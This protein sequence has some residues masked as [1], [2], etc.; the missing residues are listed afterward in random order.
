MSWSRARWAAILGSALH[1]FATVILLS[2]HLPSPDLEGIQSIGLHHLLPGGSL[3]LNLDGAG[4]TIAIFDDGRV[5]ETHQ[6]LVGRVIHFNNLQSTTIA[7]HATG[8]A[9]LIGSAGVQSG[10]IGYAPA[11]IL[12]VYKWNQFSP[13]NIPDLYTCAQNG[14]EISNHSYATKPGWNYLSGAW[15]WYGSDSISLI[16]DWRFGYYDHQRSRA[17]D[18]VLWQNPYHLAVFAAG[19][20]RGNGPSP[21]DTQYYYDNQAQQWVDIT[22]HPTIHP[23]PDGGL[24]GFDCLGPEAVAKNVL[25][26][27]AVSKNTSGYQTPQ[28]IILDSNSAF[29]PTDDGRIKPEVVAPSDA[30]YTPSSS[31]DN[32]Y[33]TISRTSAATAVASGTALL[34]KTYFNR[35]YGRNPL[36]STLRALI[37][38]SA[39]RFGQAP[40][41][42]TGFG[43]LNAYKAA[44]II[45][46][47][48]LL[49]NGGYYIREY[50]LY[51]GQRILVP[52][53]SKLND[54]IRIT[55]AWTD[56]HISALPIN[57]QVLN[58]RTSRLV[59]DLDI[60]LYS[61]DQSNVFH[62]YKGDPNQPHL[63]A[64]TGDNVV[65]N[66]EM[67]ELPLNQQGNF[68]LQ[69]THKG[70][71]SQGLQKF[72][73]VI[74]GVEEPKVFKATQNTLWFNSQNWTSNNLPDSNALVFLPASIN[75]LF[76]DSNAKVW[77]I[78]RADS[79]HI[80][81]ADPATLQ[82]Q[83]VGGKGY[84]T[85]KASAQN[86]AGISYS[87]LSN[88]KFIR[89]LYIQAKAGPYSGRWVYMGL[90]PGV[91]LQKL[92]PQQ[93]TLVNLNFPG[94]SL[95]HW[96]ASIGQYQGFNSLNHIP[97]QGTGILAFFGSNSLGTF[98]MALPDTLLIE[99]E[100]D[101]LYSLQIPIDYTSSPLNQNINQV[102][103]GWNLIANPYPAWYDWYQQPVPGN[104]TA[105]YH[106]N[107]LTGQWLSYNNGPDSLRY[108]AP[109]QAFWVRNASGSATHLSFDTSR[110]EKTTAKHFFKPQS[111]LIEFYLRVSHQSMPQ[112]SDFVIIGNRPEATPYFDGQW[113]ALKFSNRS[114]NPSISV[115]TDTLY[116]IYRTHNAILNVPLTLHIH[117]EGVYCFETSAEEPL[118]LFDL[119]ENKSFTLTKNTK[120]CMP[121]SQGVHTQRFVLE[122][123]PI[124]NLAES[125]CTTPTVAKFSEFFIVTNPSSHPLTATLYSLQGQVVDKLY[126]APSS[127][128]KRI[129]ARRGVFVL[130]LKSIEFDK[131]FKLLF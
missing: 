120:Q 67:I 61:E 105:I 19:N 117:Q 121:V 4:D 80:A 33:T 82:A 83:A 32:S 6:E 48:S 39:D 21:G 91:S 24:L 15:Y 11:V 54:S 72:S 90:P 118:Q 52:I 9:G 14:V 88:T 42:K 92:V 113:D 86:L 5:R 99:Y 69:I 84:I 29:G 30:L 100:A 56:P 97:S 111:T 18:S 123:I 3:G 36:S 89:Q 108:I 28:D 79:N 12:H 50:T 112:L 102:S 96:N 45:R 119:L 16:E 63:P 31:A 57:A 66:V 59:N 58:N 106:F 87:K 25:T 55:I 49:C 94:G 73:L 129:I 26:V 17:L 34:L 37:V 23:Q 130:H 35:V 124:V 98:H 76:I 8:I 114:P 85:L 127:T 75:T 2:L 71:L 103:D 128:E 95:L 1:P 44:E 22:N 43:V 81:I 51:Q 60:R 65:D 77:A 46:D 131:A 41:Y 101:S 27:G 109:H 64:T 107:D 68:L 10:A 116:S 93:N 7:S 47:D 125:L 122:H 115:G 110:I 40:N 20:E 74:S 38:H 70:T 53:K 126:V 62:P 104:A 78:D 13:I